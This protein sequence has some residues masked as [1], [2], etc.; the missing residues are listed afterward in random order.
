MIVFLDTSALVKLVVQENDSRSVRNLVSGADSVAVSWL[1]YPEACSAVARRRREGRHSQSDERVC[2][3]R[4][5]ALANQLV[6][7]NVSRNI[8]RLAGQLVGRHTIRGA[9]AVHVA[10]ALDLRGQLQSPISFATFDTRQM[11][12]AME[13]GLTIAT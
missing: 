11:A 12:A 9:D 5:D 13:E 6:V 8:A 3:A 2:I 10:S 1:A 7:I 4:L